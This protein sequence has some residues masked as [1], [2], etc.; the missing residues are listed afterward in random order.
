VINIRTV[1][2]APHQHRGLSGRT[3]RLLFDLLSD[4]VFCTISIYLIVL[5]RST[6]NRAYKLTLVRKINL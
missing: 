4:A 6:C 1:V 5:R 3:L 2:A